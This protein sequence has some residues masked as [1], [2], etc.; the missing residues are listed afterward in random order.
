MSGTSAKPRAAAP[1]DLH[2]AALT[3]ALRHAFESPTYRPPTLPA[4]AMEL[5]QLASGSDVPFGEV[6]KVLDRD[7]VLAAR[8]LSIAQSPVYA[9]RSPV[10]SLQQ[11]AV[12]L[13][14]KGV[15]DLALEAALH[16]KVFRVPGYDDVMARLYRHSTATAHV[17]RAMCKRF[18]V[19]F[20]YAFLAGL[21]HDVGFAAELLALV[22]TPEWRGAP[23]QLIAPVLDAVH[24]DA[25]GQLA[26]RWR[27]PAPLQQLLANH[28]RLEVGGEVFP[29]NAA[30]VV[31]EQLCWEAGAGMLPPPPEADADSGST[32]EQPSSGFDANGPDVLEAARSLLGIDDEAMGEA[33]RE[34]FAAVAALGGKA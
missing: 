6:V 9:S 1:S 19:K 29:A 26:M 4:A 20:D 10:L 11:A 17:M 7:P 14:L 21:L 28:H 24:T 12:R 27:L 32:P 34:A 22:S 33:R 2:A 5:M 8:V 3:L 30:L 13:G 15:R 23:F 31:A 18:R 25:S 16:A